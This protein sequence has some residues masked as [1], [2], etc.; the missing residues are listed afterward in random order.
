MSNDPTGFQTVDEAPELQPTIACR[1]CGTDAEYVGSVHGRFSGQDFELRRCPGCRFAFIADPVS[2]QAAVYDER[3]Y[4]GHGADPLVDY[5]F[6]LE[7]PQSTVRVYEWNGIER[8]VADLVGDL[9]A[10]RWLDY[11]CGNGGLVRHLRQRGC[12]ALGFE[13]GAIVADAASVGVPTVSRNELDGL[14]GSFD[15]IS[16]IEVLEHVLDPLAELRAMR[17]LLRSGGLLFVT[18]GNAAPFADRLCAWSYVI[19]EI[20]VSLFEPGTLALALRRAGF[21]PE[22]RR[23]GPGFDDVLKFKVLKNLRIRRRSAV[24]DR[25]P[26]RLVAAPADRY[27]RLS[28]HPIGW[29]I[30]G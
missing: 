2:D 20:H 1:L 3:Y 23:L 28:H 5:R 30:D 22:R 12:A 24:L 9:S 6:E 25:I 19:P 4:D 18:T 13:E 29:A 14:A 15:V 17:R 8:V 7:Q 26:A 21:R 10:V 27:A 16:A 11:G